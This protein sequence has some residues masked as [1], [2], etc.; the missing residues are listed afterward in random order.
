M[1]VENAD[2]TKQEA[3]WLEDYFLHHIFVLTPLAIDPAH[4]FPFIPNLGSSITLRLAGQ[5]E[6]KALNA[7]IRLP[8][9]VERF[10]RLPDFADT[11]A[12]RFIALE[13][14]IVRFT[15]RLFL[16]RAR[17]RAPSGSS[18]TAIS[19]WKRRRRISSVCSRPH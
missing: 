12:T 13:Q 6:A 3:N 18:A 9:K 8:N 11:G 16:T 10:I 4:P 1:L 14:V 5:G 7:L 15:S 2:L 17:D 19:R